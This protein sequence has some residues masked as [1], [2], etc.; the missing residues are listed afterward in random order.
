MNYI[1]VWNPSDKKKKKLNP[2]E[3]DLSELNQN[4]GFERWWGGKFVGTSQTVQKWKRPDFGC[5]QTPHT[6][7]RTPR[8][9]AGP[10]PPSSCCLSTCLWQNLSAF[11]HQLT[12]IKAR[13]WTLNLQTGTLVHRW[14]WGWPP[15][16]H[17]QHQSGSLTLHSVNYRAEKWAISTSTTTPP[18]E[19]TH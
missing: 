6:Q 17:A 2:L 4:P 18:P 10:P 19:H 11:A 12:S 13:G 9:W 16:G 7:A 1:K 8:W 14:S 15:A 3:F 5:T